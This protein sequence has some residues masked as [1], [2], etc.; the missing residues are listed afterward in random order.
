MTAV[1]KFVSDEMAAELMRQ[2]RDSYAAEIVEMQ[3]KIIELEADIT[4]ADE[5]IKELRTRNENLYQ[6]IM[7]K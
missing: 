4:T 1:G 6:Q 7:L 3:V 5:T 2:V